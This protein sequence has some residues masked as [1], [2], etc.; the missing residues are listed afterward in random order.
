MLAADD[1]SEP[2]EVVH[3]FTR[4]GRTLAVRVRYIPGVSDRGHLFVFGDARDGCLVR[5][6]S[7][8]LYGEAMGSD[9]CDCGPELELALDLIYRER[10][11][12]LIY[13]EQEGRGSGLMAKAQGY[14]YSQANRTDT[15]ESYE[16]LGLAPDSRDYGGAI[17]ALCAL[18]FLRS[19][20]L[21]TNNPRKVIALR[22]AG[23]DVS[24]VRLYTKPKGPAAAAYLDAKRRQR[25]DIRHGL[26]SPHAWWWLTAAKWSL[27]LAGGSAVALSVWSMVQHWQ[28]NAQAMAAALAFALSVAVTRLR[29]RAGP[30]RPLSPWLAATWDRWRPGFAHV[31]AAPLDSNPGEVLG[32]RGV[33]RDTA[34]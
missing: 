29:W 24:R 18:G 32:H 30:A 4:K 16:R 27:R 1:S 17:D 28:L 8:C 25:G 21:L 5:I 26:L 33:A 9:S 3:Q 11:G 14:A 13:L 19:V 31:G 12:V 15:F 2:T 34:A 6:H 7:Q 22:D 20:K 10:A 23:F